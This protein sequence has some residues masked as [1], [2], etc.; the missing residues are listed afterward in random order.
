MLAPG[1][2]DL[3]V[4]AAI[5]HLHEHGFAR[6]GKVLDDGARAEL[7]ARADALMLGEIADPGLFF[8]KD[9]DTGRYG[10]LAFGKGFEGPSLN[11][12]KIE[13][14]EKD[15]SFRAWIE[16][17][18]FERIARAVIA[19]PISIYRCALFG[20]AAN[21]GTVLPWHQDGGVFWGL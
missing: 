1:A 21:G 9:T 4:A 8:Q 15:A 7:R 5:A 18:L 13:K 19:G 12:R 2:L 10:D 17:P 6:L 11:Y 20:K 14:L 16:N 3:D